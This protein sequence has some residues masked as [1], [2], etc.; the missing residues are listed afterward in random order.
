[1]EIPFCGPTYNGRSL[2]VDASRSVN[3]YLELTGTTDNKAQMIMVGTPGLQIFTANIATNWNVVAR[4]L[5]SFN[6]VLWAVVGNTLYSGATGGIF[7]SRG[8]LATTTGRVSFS[9]N[10]LGSMSA[11]TGGNQLIIVDGTSGYLYNV[12]TSTFSTIASSAG[13]AD[14]I[15]S[16][17]PKQVEFIDGY[18]VVT[19][20]T[21]AFWVSDLYDGTTWQALATATVSATP[22]TIQSLINHRQQIFYIKQYSTELWF[23]TG[24]T[25]TTQGSPLAR[26]SGAVYDYGTSAPWSVAK[27]GQSFYFLCN[28]RTGDGGEFLGVA[29]VTDYTPVMVSTPAI[30]YRISQSTTLA[31]CFGYCY[32]DQGHIFYVLTNPDDNWTLVYDAATK[33]WHERSSLTTS[34]GAV[35]RHLGNCY[36][37]FNGKHY[38][39]D[40]RSSAIYEMSA[41]YYSDF[42][43][44]IYSFRTAQTIQDANMRDNVFI[45]KLVIDAETGVGNSTN[46]PTATIP[47]PAGWSGSSNV[48]IKADGS[49]TAG[50]ILLSDTNPQ[51]MLDWSDDGGHTWSSQ[52]SKSLGT[53][54]AYTTRLV[55]TRLGKARDRVFRVCIHDNVKKVLINAFIE[56]AL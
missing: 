50:A 6:G 44:P 25:D 55:W 8:T 52:Y 16:G 43:N 40:Y 49:I 56:G 14:L 47:Y 22:D 17:G 15:A 33:M 10:G 24:T 5:Y 38:V 51:A 13:W 31:N 9:N 12:V 35:N 42:G 28:T 48:L 19:N 45:S 21:Q 39:G 23:D 54:G 32:A 37:F 11:G 4:G 27:G 34:T 29:E 30:A 18:F 2:N 20:G 41:A 7:T 36:S 46:L 26:Q 53:S 1:M 3:F